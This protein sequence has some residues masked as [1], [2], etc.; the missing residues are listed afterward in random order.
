MLIDSDSWKPDTISETFCKFRSVDLESIDV[1]KLVI[2]FHFVYLHT[3][4]NCLYIFHRLLVG[5]C[6]G[7][8]KPCSST[9]RSKTSVWGDCLRCCRLL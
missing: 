1:M 8:V 5:K 4:Q 6:D 9:L 2:E 7:Q 3:S